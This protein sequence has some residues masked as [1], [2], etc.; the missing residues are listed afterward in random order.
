MGFWCIS[1]NFQTASLDQRVRVT[2]S[3]DELINKITESL[4][5]KVFV[6]TCNRIE[7]YSFSETEPELL[8]ERW[9]NCLKIDSSEAEV[10][11]IYRNKE[12]L[13]H[14]FRVSSSLESM[15]LGE[16]QISG[17]IRK[18]YQLAV[19]KNWVQSGLHQIFQSAFRAAKRVR[20]E[21][22]VGQFAVSI[23][24][25]GVKL[26]E[27]ILG[28]LSSRVVGVL[29][30]GEIG[31]VAAEHFGSVCPKKLLLYNRTESKAVDFADKLKKEAVSCEVVSSPDEILSRANVIISAVS[32]KLLDQ[33][34]LSLI[35]SRTAPIFILDLAVP[36]IFPKIESDEVFLYFVDDLRK[37]AE[38]NSK[39]RDKEL[40]RAGDIVAEEVEKVWLRLAGASASQTFKLLEEKIESIRV[41]ELA[42]LKPRLQNLSEDEWLAV[43][44][45]A[46]RLGLKI[47]QDPMLE[48]RTRLENLDEEA[49]QG[50]TWIKYF[51]NLFRL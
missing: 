26:A 5:D 50:E 16:S 42:A 10:F 45:M 2:P 36:P 25:V 7:L 34:Q 35:N 47:L 6:S 28:D 17:Q 18:A 3:S 19:S 11:K 24:S 20:S 29:G 30:L 48:L 21:T 38:D 15:V 33:Q 46:E 4:E 8:K 13:H 49:F 40:N 12:A 32:E 23:P 44:K 1:V 39:L 31:R 9:M 41:S 22:E 27:R 14:L 43:E 51:R 37:I